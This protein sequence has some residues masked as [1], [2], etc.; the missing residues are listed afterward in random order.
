MTIVWWGVAIL[1]ASFLASW[2]AGDVGTGDR[3]RDD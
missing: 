3:Y 1:V 2:L